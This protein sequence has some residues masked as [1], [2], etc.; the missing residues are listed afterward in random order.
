[1]DQEDTTDIFHTLEQLKQRISGGEDESSDAEH[2]GQLLHNTDLINLLQLHNKL[3]KEIPNDVEARNALE[4]VDDVQKLHENHPSND[5]L[6]VL[7]TLFHNS[8]HL[9]SLL[10]AHDKIANNDFGEPQLTDVSVD[11]YSIEDEKE[12]ETM[13]V[14][15]LVKSDEPLG[16]TI[17]DD[18]T[19]GNIIIARILKGGAAD[20]SGLIHI[21]DTIVEINGVKTK[22]KKPSDVI[23]ILAGFTGPLTLRL[24][25]GEREEDSN[26]VILHVK[27]R[28]T[29]QPQNDN[30]IPCREAGLQFFPNEI[31]RVVSK[32]DKSWWQ[33]YKVDTSNNT[34]EKIVP[35]RA[36]LIP[37]MKLQVRREKLQKQAQLK[38]SKTSLKGNKTSLLK[39]SRKNAANVTQV[40]LHLPPYEIVT[41]LSPVME[42]N[43]KRIYRPIVLVGPQGVGRNDL[44]DRLIDSNP[45]HY[46]VPVPHTSRAMHQGEE[47]GKDYHFVSREFMENGIRDNFFFEY[48]EY[49]G[50]LYGTSLPAVESV[51]ESGQVCV[52]T[53]YPQALTALRIRKIKPYIVFLKPEQSWKIQGNNIKSADLQ[54]MLKRAEA[55]EYTYGR[56]FDAVIQNDSIESSFRHLKNISFSLENSQ[57]W[58]PE[59]WVS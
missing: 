12:E 6:S 28:F 58:V 33:A 22:D 36:G 31:L 47:N 11:D 14:V 43:G 4:L 27:T 29:F 44:K 50:S 40:G 3:Q 39:E 15:R 57:Q 13:K 41:Q 54:T 16:A 59:A 46:G 32:V 1:M 53:P 38:V 35:A 19:T 7:A 55:I 48:G 52:L 42:Q 30:L 26:E 37:S 24:I 23:K 51:I 20:R 45:T 25:P 9:I 18:E 49:K 5:I 56:L 2:L 34:N 10:V 17:V 8:H 21:N